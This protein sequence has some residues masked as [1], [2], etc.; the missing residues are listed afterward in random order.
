MALEDP[1]VPPAA[2]NRDLALIDVARVIV[3]AALTIGSVLLTAFG[4]VE[5][6]IGIEKIATD[7]RYALL[8]LMPGAAALAFLA[9][10]RS[11]GAI[12][13]VTV[14]ARRVST[15][16]RMLLRAGDLSGAY[17]LFALVISA[18]VGVATVIAVAL[19]VDLKLLAVSVV[20]G[21]VAFLISIL[22]M[23]TRSSPGRKVTD[24]VLVLAIV[25]LMLL[26]LVT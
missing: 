14:P 22:G 25:A 3:T 21:V 12:Y 18:L 17:G 6:M 11:L 16:K 26:D 24:L 9:S 20:A 7:R 5:R 4:F 23:L 1:A 15:L 13:D 19:F 8:A 10:A 2:F